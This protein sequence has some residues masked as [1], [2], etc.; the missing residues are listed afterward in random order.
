MCDAVVQN[1]KKELLLFKGYIDMASS[2]VVAGV[3]RIDDAT[4]DRILKD[5]ISPSYY[6]E[7]KSLYGGRVRWRV[8][9]HVFET[10]SKLTVAAG[11]VLSFAAGFYDNASLSFMAGTFSTASMAAMQFA[12]YCLAESK[13]DSD[14][15][16]TL[17]TNLKI[18]PIPVLQ[19]EESGGSSK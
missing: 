12:S 11:V 16:N 9:G 10:I 14:Q 6:T 3:E 5:L 18:S 13:Q 19:E 17:L 7:V 2:M 8:A 15:L 4:R 1:K